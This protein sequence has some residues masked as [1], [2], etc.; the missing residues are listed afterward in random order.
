[1]L[2]NHVS[3]GSQQL[4]GV[5]EFQDAVVFLFL[6]V[7]RIEKYEVGLQGFAE[8]APHQHLQPLHCIYREDARGNGDSQRLEILVDQLRCGTLFFDEEHFGS[9]AAERLD[10]HCPRPRVDIHK[11]GPF[12]RSAE[13][14][15]Q[16]F[17]E[18]I[19][20]RAQ[21]ELPR[22]LQDTAAIF[23]GDDPQA[24]THLRQMIAVVPLR[25]Q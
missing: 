22:A 12:H 4:R 25:R 16:R 19:A 7:R 1:M 5:Q 18:F 13:N 21:S 17:A 24:S 15:E 11:D 6:L 8:F 23:A 10:A 14:I 3:G 20:R 9:A 2:H